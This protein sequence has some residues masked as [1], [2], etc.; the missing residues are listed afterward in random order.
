MEEPRFDDLY[1]DVILDHYRRPRGRKPLERP[2]VE[3]EGINPLCGDEVKVS[4]Q[5]ENDRIKDVAIAGRGCAI[6]TASG[7]IL[8]ELLPGRT[9]AEVEQLADGFKRMMHDGGIPEGLEIGD[10]DAL[11][12]VKKYPVRIKCALLS[13]VTLIDAIKSWRSGQTKHATTTT[14]S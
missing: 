8:A 6:S 9:L 5:I 4:V 12:G 14:E 13:W 7:S 1:R 10:L 3:N 11:E 2:D